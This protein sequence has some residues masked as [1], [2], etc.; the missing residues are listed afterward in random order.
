VT[1][2]QVYFV[3]RTLHKWSILIFIYHV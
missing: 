3:R 1:L 2:G